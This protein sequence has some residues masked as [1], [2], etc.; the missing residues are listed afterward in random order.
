MGQSLLDV[1]GIWETSRNL[2]PSH[3]EGEGRLPSQ[4]GLQ[5]H[6]KEG[7][8]RLRG[9]GKLRLCRSQ[10]GRETDSTWPSRPLTR[11]KRRHKAWRR[12]RAPH[13]STPWGLAARRG[14]RDTSRYCGSGSRL[15]QQRERVS[16]TAKRAAILLLAGGRSRL[17][18]VKC[19]SREARYA[20]S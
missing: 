10:S 14:H 5:T 8:H 15:S 1:Q 19:R 18:L 17:R 7:G 13:S 16:H 20:C 9:F 6:Q 12:R 2:P 4:Y 11:Q 3:L